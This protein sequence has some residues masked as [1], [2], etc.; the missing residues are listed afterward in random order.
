MRS[1]F[2][3]NAAPIFSNMDS[4]MTSLSQAN[5]VRMLLLMVPS[6]NFLR[7]FSMIDGMSLADI[8]CKYDSKHA[9]IILRDSLMAAWDSVVMIYD[10]IESKSSKIAVMALPSV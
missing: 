8:L 10:V 4:L 7:I 3:I 6:I 2:P 1:T 5:C 9:S